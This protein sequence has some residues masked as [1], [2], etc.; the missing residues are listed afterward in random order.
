MKHHVQSTGAILKFFLPYIRTIQI[1]CLR[2]GTT[3]TESVEGHQHP[4]FPIQPL[5]CNNSSILFCTR[6]FIRFPYSTHS[7]TVRAHTHTIHNSMAS[8]THPV[9][10]SLLLHPRSTLPKPHAPHLLS[11]SSTTPFS[12]LPRRRRSSA[13]SPPY[14]P[15]RRRSS[16]P[17]CLAY[18]TGPPSDPIAADN[19]PRLNASSS[20]NES[21]QSRSPPSV[22]SWGLLSSLLLQHKLRLALSVA[23]LVGC[24]A[25]TLS[26]PLYS[27]KE[28]FNFL[29]WCSVRHVIVWS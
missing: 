4:Q 12:L 27:G 2:F 7:T 21:T 17:T 13:L 25:C 16:R 5:T 28:S 15:L 20:V 24:T 1:T 26:M 6:T 19:G 14:R 8:P 11:L 3:H 18:V 23:T 9:P 10:F 22:V 29:F